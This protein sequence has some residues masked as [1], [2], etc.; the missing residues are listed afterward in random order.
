MVEY[1]EDQQHRNVVDFALKRPQGKITPQK[2]NK[3]TVKR[4]INVKC[5]ENSACTTRND[6]QLDKCD[7]I[8]EMVR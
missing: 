3:E 8:Y 5:I 6:L 1:E 2:E 7:T 4:Y